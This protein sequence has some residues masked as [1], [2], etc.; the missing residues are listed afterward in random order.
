MQ[1]LTL[2]AHDPH[3]QHAHTARLTWPPPADQQHP[4]TATP[5][6]EGPA[7]SGSATARVTT[8]TLP[9]GLDLQDSCRTGAHLCEGVRACR[10]EGGLLVRGGGG[11]G[12]SQAGRAWTSDRSL[13]A[14]VATVPLTHTPGG[15]GCLGHDAPQLG[16]LGE[17][18]AQHGAV[19]PAHTSTQ[20]RGFGAGTA[21]GTRAPV[22]L[23]CA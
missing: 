22:L 15:G 10:E 9:P 3:H 19:V 17:H 8:A 18:G 6:S 12:V 1:A 21:A 5:C 20:C 11:A 16:V 13:R 14:V 23:S 2:S 7:S 4:T